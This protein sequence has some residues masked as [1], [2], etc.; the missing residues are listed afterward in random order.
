MAITITRLITVGVT[1][2]L[3]TYASHIKRAP[4]NGVYEVWA[5]SDV[6]DTTLNCKL[7]NEEILGTSEVGSSANN[8]IDERFGADSVAVAAAGETMVIAVTE[9]TSMSARV[10]VRFTEL[11]E[12]GL[13]RV[14]IHPSE[15]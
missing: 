6:E 14:G 2:F 10:R 3:E 7:G 12:W 4:S 15:M 13:L 5:I 8:Y 11:E 1:D 9:V